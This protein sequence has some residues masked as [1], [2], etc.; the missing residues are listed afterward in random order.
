MKELFTYGLAFMSRIRIFVCSVMDQ[1]VIIWP[2]VK[3]VSYRHKQT[4]YLYIETQYILY[5]WRFQ[6]TNKEGTYQYYESFKITNSQRFHHINFSSLLK[7]N[8]QKLNFSVSSCL[9]TS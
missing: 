5:K 7:F 6:Y 1:N 2:S 4:N 3:S 8:C 9:H